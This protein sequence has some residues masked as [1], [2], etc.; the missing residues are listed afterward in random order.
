[1]VLHGKIYYYPCGSTLAYKKSGKLITVSRS[2]FKSK[3]FY[4]S[5]VQVIY[6]QSPDNRTPQVLR[7]HFHKLNIAPPRKFMEERHFTEQDH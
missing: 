7:W 1:M 5:I 4:D 2:M 3:K 6:R